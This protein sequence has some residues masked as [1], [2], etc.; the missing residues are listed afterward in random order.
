L[1]L[2]RNDGV[3]ETNVENCFES[4]TLKVGTTN[5]ARTYISLTSYLPTGTSLNYF[6]SNDDGTTYETF[7]PDTWHTFSTSDNDYKVK[8]CPNSTNSSNSPFVADYRAQIVPSAPTG[9]S[10][11]IGIDGANDIDINYT[12]NSTTTPWNYTG[13]D[14]GFND[15]IND[16]CQDDSYCLFPMT[17]ILGSGGIIELSN[18][19]LT[20][21]INPV[22]FNTTAIQTLNSIPIKPTYTNGTVQFDDI[23]VDF[24]GSQNITVYSH[25][26]S[27]DGN[28]NRTIFVK[29]S[30]F[31]VTYWQD[32]NYW[33]I[34][35][36]EANQSDLEPYG[37]NSS[38]GIW[39][40]DSFAYD[41]NIDIW[42]RYNNTENLSCVTQMEFRGQN[43]TDDPL[44]NVSTMN[45]T[46]LT[47]SN[48]QIISD[49][50][51]TYFGNIRTYTMINCSEYGASAM[52]VPY[53]CFNSL[54]SSCVETS[55]MEDSCEVVE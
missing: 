7:V 32:W 30:P 40:V 37:Q 23:Q 28:L 18:L 26:A 25:N 11:D 29:Y 14:S 41:G 35:P 39:K 31:N 48:Q 17:F 45:I 50:N 36:T 8:F 10:I 38:H 44:N 27:Y 20:Q 24:R 49:L 47:A 3:F 53:F 9:M 33:L 15:Y 4:N 21:D 13:N 42:A 51:S 2:K 16:S 55:D 1:R 19:N 12:L 22:R 34:R 6:I 43:F 54:C 5:I 52:L 46:S